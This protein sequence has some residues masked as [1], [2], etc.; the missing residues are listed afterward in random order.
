MNVRVRGI[1]TTALTGLI[2]DNEDWQV[3]QASD[4]IA[5][6]FDRPFESAPAAVSVDTTDDRQGVGVHG[7]PEGVDAVAT[8]LAGLGRDTFVWADP[9]PPDAV[10]DARVTETLGSG[11]VVDLG[12]TEAFLPYGNTEAHVETGDELRVQVEGGAP[13]WADD[14]PVVDTSLEIRGGLATLVRGGQ[15]VT[16]GAADVVDLISTDPPEGWAV[17]WGRDT[18]D[19]AFDVLDDALAAASERAAALDTALSEA[20]PTAENAPGQ[21]WSGTAGRWCWFGRESRFTLDERRAATVATMPGHH[22]IKAGSRSASAA[23]DFVEAV[24]PDLGSEGAKDGA[25]DEDFPFDVVTRQFGPREGDQLAIDHGKP[26]GRCIRLGTGDVAERD[27]GGTVTLTRQMSPGGTYDA[28]GTPREA[29]DVAVTKF[30]EGRWWYAT[31]YRDTEDNRKGTYVNV[32]TPVEIFPESVRY[33]DLHV[34]VV[35][36]ADG[37]V[38]RV[39]DD[40]LDAA[41]A[42]G[43]VTEPLAEKARSVASAVENAL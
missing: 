18:E 12:G 32:C 22:R 43:D 39:D 17:R 37:S 7:D 16:T 42:D 21:V 30:K 36:H 5:D 28:L 34:D 35:K 20:S 40:E 15:Q 38:E 33:V 1:Y 2:A 9:A 25:A 4:A 41:V 29:G 23:V 8:E 11:A 13:P 14:R 19:V 3:V 24:C 31:V 26:A 6:R 27:P 10:F